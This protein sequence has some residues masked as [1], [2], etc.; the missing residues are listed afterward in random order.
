MRKPLLLS[1]MVAGSVLS[2]VGMTGVFAPFTDQAQTGTSTP[3]RVESADRPPE[4][5]IKVGSFQAGVCGNFADN[6]LTGLIDR[7]DVPQSSNTFGQ[8]YCVQNAGSSPI[9]VTVKPVNIVETETGCTG[10]EDQVDATCTDGV[11]ELGAVLQWA[12]STDAIASNCVAKNAA[13]SFPQLN[14][15]AG[16]P[17]YTIGVLAPGEVVCLGNDFT[18][19]AGNSNALIASQ[20][21]QVTFRFQFDATT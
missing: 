12:P 17:T 10:N 18:Y 16:A 11:G 4:A 13:G 15:P 1:V 14:D 6:T 21:D 19:P 3:E 5:D 9:T 2:L 20:S 7:T 8:L